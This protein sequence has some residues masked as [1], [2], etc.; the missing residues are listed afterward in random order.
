MEELETAVQRM[1]GQLQAETEQAAASE[2]ATTA[3]LAAR[4]DAA[5]VPME[6]DIEQLE[7][8]LRQA[9]AHET[10]S[11][12]LRQRLRA[13]IEQ[14]TEQVQAAAECRAAA[15]ARIAVAVQDSRAEL[16]HHISQLEQH[17]AAEQE[18]EAEAADFDTSAGAMLS[19]GSYADQ[20]QRGDGAEVCKRCL[21]AATAQVSTCHDSSAL[22]LQL[23]CISHA[24]PQHS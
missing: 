4:I 2:A 5:T 8:Q 1:Q 15:D 12:A 11:Q 9:A 3:D 17:G 14:L 13:D 18:M 16:E 6:A 10:A 21:A 19:E 7:D 20:E 23:T 22:E 24:G